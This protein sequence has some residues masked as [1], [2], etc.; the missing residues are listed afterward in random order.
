MKLKIMNYSQEMVLTVS[1][2]LKELVINKED[3]CL[4]LELLEESRPIEVPMFDLKNA[5]EESPSVESGGEENDTFV[6]PVVE[7]ESAFHKRMSEDCMFERLAMLRKELAVADEVPPYLI[8]HNKTLREM[9]EKLPHDMRSLG[10]V[11]GVGRA[12]LEKYGAQFLAI[13]NGAA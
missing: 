9:A 12:K 11:S 6:L 10:A 7:S 2:E 13:I 3:G 4:I 5:Q 1:G 8:F